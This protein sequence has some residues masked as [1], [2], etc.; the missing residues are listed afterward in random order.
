MVPLSLKMCPRFWVARLAVL[1]LSFRDGGGRPRFGI[2][3]TVG[4]PVARGPCWVHGD[5]E[6]SESRDFPFRSGTECSGVSRAG[7]WSVL[8]KLLRNERG[9]GWRFPGWGGE[10]TAVPS[11]A[12]TY[13]SW[14]HGRV[15]G[16]LSPEFTRHSPTPPR[17]V[18]TSIVVTDASPPR[19]PSPPPC[20]GTSDPGRASPASVE[21][22]ESSVPSLRL[23]AAVEGNTLL[24]PR[25]LCGA[26]RWKIRVLFGDA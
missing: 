9:E 4:A 14:E 7:T 12:S 18:C 23:S 19:S 26:G 13:D 10:C 16:S 1:S 17:A 21:G 6:G 8:N 25:W 11:R 20:A 3:R 2:P 15:P 22:Q 5:G 24:G